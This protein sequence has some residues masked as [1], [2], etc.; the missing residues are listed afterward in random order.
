MR[1]C[2]CSFFMLLCNYLLGNTLCDNESIIVNLDTHEMKRPN[3]PSYIKKKKQS[4]ERYTMVVYVDKNDC[5]SCFI[6]HLYEWEIFINECE[7]DKIPLNIVF[8]FSPPENNYTMFVNNLS[9][10]SISSVS[11]ID[12]KN[13]FRKKNPWVIKDMSTHIFI[14]DKSMRP[15]FVDAPPYDK[16]FTKWLHGLGNPIE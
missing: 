5:P 12:T 9:T 6:S 10:S 13:R 7:N 4:N 8:I 1:T 11:Y 3:V 2:I 15:K 14:V 16:K